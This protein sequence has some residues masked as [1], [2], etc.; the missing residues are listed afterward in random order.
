MQLFR[1]LECLPPEERREL[2]VK[3][4]GAEATD[5]AEQNELLMSLLRF[6]CDDKQR[7]HTHVAPGQTPHG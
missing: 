1:A 5:T 7:K 2:L 3:L 4:D 6:L